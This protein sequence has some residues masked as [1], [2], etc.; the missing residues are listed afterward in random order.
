MA[1]YTTLDAVKRDLDVGGA[2]AGADNDTAIGD[3]ISEASDLIDEYKGVEEGAYKAGDAGD[4]TRYFNGSGLVRQRIDPAVSIT[5]VAV[6][7]TDG[8]Y[9]TW[10]EDTD[11]FNWPENHDTIDEPIR[12]LEV[13][14]KSDGNKS[15]FTHGQRRVEVTA[16]FGISSSTPAIIERACKIQVQRWI[17][18]AQQGFA[19]SSA[20]PDLGRVL[21]T[22]ELDPDVMTLLDKAFPRRKS[23]I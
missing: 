10:T 4:E 19:D 3:M 21:F 17:K 18:R 15:V 8:T 6:E 11:Y 12:Y 1:D 20:N 16:T 23:G 5:S 7:E 9:T 2:T 22:R 14:Q 13:N